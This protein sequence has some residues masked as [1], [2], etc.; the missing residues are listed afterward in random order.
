KEMTLRCFYH[1]DR[2]SVGSCKSCG[3]GLCPDCL[4]DMGK[5][6]ACRSRC[7]TEVQGLIIASDVNVS[8][9]AK[10]PRQM[11]ANRLMVVGLAWLF[12]IPGALLVALGVL[13]GH[14]T[15]G[16]VFAGGF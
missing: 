9:A 14:P 5:G 3:K 16:Y 13:A 11:R 15:E 1:Q 2:E 10:V 12:V 6:L 7:E 4:V 8:M